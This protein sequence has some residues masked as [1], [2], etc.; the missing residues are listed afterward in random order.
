MLPQFIG[1]HKAAVLPG[2]AGPQ[3]PLCLSAPLTAQQ[4]HHEVGGRD[5]SPPVIFKWGQAVPPFAA[6]VPR[7]LEL[8]VDQQCALVEVHT[9]PAKAQDLS[10]SQP[11]E[12]RNKVHKFKTVT[13]DRLHEPADGFIVQRFYLLPYDPGKRAGIRRIGSQVSDPNGLLEGFVEYS[14]NIFYAL[15]R[16]PGLAEIVVKMLDSVC[17]QQI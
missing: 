1:K 7:P 9:S 4:I 16:K 8:L 6:A 14:M 3:A 13:L 12:Q 15:W 10:L 5:S 11:R 2:R 17:V